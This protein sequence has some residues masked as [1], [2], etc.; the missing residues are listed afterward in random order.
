MSGDRVRVLTI[1]P[2][3]ALQ[4]VTAALPFV[5]IVSVPADEPPRPGLTADV[6]LTPPWDTGHLDAL[7]ATGVRWVHTIG[8]GVDR[9]PL[10]RLGDRVLSCSRGASAVP[11]AE[12][13]LAVMLAFAKDLPGCWLDAP[14][15]PVGRVAPKLG[16]LHGARLG[17][18]GFGGIGQAVARHAISFGMRVCA[19]RRSGRA[20]EIEG[21]EVVDA[22]DAVLADA[23][24]VVLALPLTESTRRLVDA[25]ALAAIPRDSGMH[26]V[27]VSRGG[28]IDQEAFREALD[29]GRIARATLDVTDPEPL[30][31]GHWLF[32]HPRARISGHVSWAAPGAFDLIL[33]TFIEN[34]ERF[35][36]DLPLRGRVDPEA[37][38]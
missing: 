17:L 36:Q 19:F 21:V 28:L 2:P 9:L 13:V 7:L 24:H 8:T 4:R 20:S 30:P 32:D 22:L 29:D 34:L 15:D 33:D 14:G 1:L 37:G 23:D 11:I 5:E 12:W 31:A 27:N 3:V 18:V 35:H 16:G 26:L 6:L 10:D 38:Y 25:A